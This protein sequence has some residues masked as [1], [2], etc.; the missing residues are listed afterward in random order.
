MSFKL[1]K[2][3]V[4]VVRSWRFIQLSAALC[5]PSRLATAT[6]RREWLLFTAT[7]TK[8]ALKDT[9]A[10][11]MHL[12]LTKTRPDTLPAILFKT[13]IK[14]IAQS[15]LRPTTLDYHIWNSLH[16]LTIDLLQFS[17][18]IIAPTHIYTH[19]RIYTQTPHSHT[20]SFTHTDIHAYT[21][22]THTYTLKMPRNESC[23]AVCTICDFRR[24]ERFGLLQAPPQVAMRFSRPWPFSGDRFAALACSAHGLN[25]GCS[26]SR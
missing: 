21:T 10:S 15:N 20:L 22:H 14:S 6:C 26:V 16:Q 17:S 3:R 19:T 8:P 25:R 2:K 13:F 23:R 4:E 11:S 18:K 7:D 12:R 5:T 1:K 9:P 24:S